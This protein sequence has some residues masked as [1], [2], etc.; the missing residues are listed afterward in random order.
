[1]YLNHPSY[2]PAVS[3]HRNTKKKKSYKNYDIQNF[4]IKG[5]NKLGACHSHDYLL[6]SCP[7]RVL[8]SNICSSSQDVS[9][10]GRAG[11]KVP[12]KSRKAPNGPLRNSEIYVAAVETSQNRGGLAKKV[13][14]LTHVTHLSV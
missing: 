9:K 12:D 1:M 14:A 10:Q 3:Y 4:F 11:K 7:D 2:S 6:Y 8:F 5:F 13:P